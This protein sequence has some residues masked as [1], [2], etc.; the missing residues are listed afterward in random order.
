MNRRRDQRRD[1]ME[2]SRLGPGRARDAGV[3]CRCPFLRYRG[4]YSCGLCEGA[5][6]FR[7]GE[8]WRRLG[9]RGHGRP[10]A[11]KKRPASGPSGRL[12]RIRGAGRSVPGC[13]VC[14][15]AG[16]EWRDSQA[17]LVSPNNAGV[18]SHPNSAG[19]RFPIAGGVIQVRSRTSKSCFESTKFVHSP[20]TS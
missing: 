20:T 16:R 13:R 8:S 3:G 17:I 14:Q 5:P 4:R 9:C 19:D 10:S 1:R 2:A 15:E 6:A 12:V 7:V 11:S 18:Q